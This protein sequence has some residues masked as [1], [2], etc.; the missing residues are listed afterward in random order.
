M[1]LKA[2]LLISLPWLI[3]IWLRQSGNFESFY[4]WS[5]NNFYLYV[6]VL[7]LLKVAGIV[8]PPLPGGILTLGSIP[9]IGWVNAY[10]IDFVGSTVGSTINYFM[11]YKYGISFLDKILDNSAV[12]KIRSM[13]IKKGK[14]LETVFML[15]VLGGTVMELVSY[16]CGVLKVKF[17]FFILVS[18]AS[19]LAIGIPTYYL[20]E[21]ILTTQNIVISLILSAALL[22]LFFRFKDRYF[23]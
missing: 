15:R 8:Y 20:A 5:Q 7:F 3:F 18:I 22:Y 6:A 21:S 17:V 10:L 11:G 23:E 12:D 2:I 9:V 16:A 13:K 4:L 1:K 14:E 19:H